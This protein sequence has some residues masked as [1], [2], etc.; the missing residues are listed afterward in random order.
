MGYASLLEVPWE[1]VSIME[2][3]FYA[4]YL[5]NNQFGIGFVIPDAPWLDSRLRSVLME[6]L[7]PDAFE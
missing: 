1:G 7:D 3:H 4:L 6:H 2:G 5:A